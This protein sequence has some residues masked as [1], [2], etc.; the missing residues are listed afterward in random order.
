[1]HRVV[2]GDHLHA[3]RPPPASRRGCRRTPGAQL[4]AEH[5]QGHRPQRGQG[6]AALRRRAAVAGSPASGEQQHPQ[7]PRCGRGPGP[8][9]VEVACGSARARGAGV[10]G[11]RARASAR[12]PCATALQRSADRNSTSS[13]T[14]PARPGS[15][16][17]G[18]ERGGG[19]VRARAPSGRTS[20]SRPRAASASSW[21]ASGTTLGER[22]PAA[23][24]RAGL[25]G[26]DDVDAAD[27]LDGVDLLDQRAAPGDAGGAHGVGDG[28]E[29]EQA[30]GHQ[31]GEHR[32]GLHEAQHGRR[33]R[34]GPGRG[35]RRSSA[36]RAAMTSRTTSSMRHCSGV[37]SVVS[38]RAAR[39]SRPGVARRRRRPRPAA[40][41]SPAGAGAA[42]EQRVAD[43]P[44]R[45][46][47]PRR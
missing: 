10:A 34:A 21:P 23:G 41:P 9:A 1:M 22:E 6:R 25:V 14:S 15:V 4:V 32:G 7:P 27:R 29:E 35:S 26:A 36:P 44:S 47:R 28:D 8:L 39:V 46:G 40:W 42:R 5:D 20:P 30:V 24:E 43:A 11:R 45:P 38:A 33:P 13:A 2:A 12:R 18:G 3:R 19:R 31:P 16:A 17:I 37:R